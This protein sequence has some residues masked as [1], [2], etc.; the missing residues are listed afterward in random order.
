MADFKITG[1]APSLTFDPDQLDKVTKSTISAENDANDALTLYIL[2]R[3]SPSTSY[4]SD[5]TLFT[6]GVSSVSVPL[7]TSILGT[8]SSSAH[9]TGNYLLSPTSSLGAE[10]VRVSG[11]NVKVNVG[12]GNT[13]GK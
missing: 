13:D 5:N 3:T 12:S 10:H 7:G 6:S 1:T 2:Y 8:I 11:N 9:I 4:N